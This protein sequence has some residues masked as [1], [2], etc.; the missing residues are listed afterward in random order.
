MTYKDKLREINPRCIKDGMYCG[1]VNGCPGDFPMLNNE[2]RMDN[3][4]CKGTGQRSDRA[5]TEC[6]NQEYI[7]ASM[8][9]MTLEEAIKHC[10]DMA[11][12]SP[13]DKNY[14]LIAD[15]LTELSEYKGTGLTPTQIRIMQAKVGDRI[16][17]AEQ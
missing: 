14:R 1:G 13:T 2:T 6:W 15:W 10:E 17:E 5:C 4:Y 9:D 8:E 12:C 16:G 3:I 7:P 11:G